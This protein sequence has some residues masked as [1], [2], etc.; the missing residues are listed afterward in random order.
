MTY[1]HYMAWLAEPFH[2]DHPSL[3]SGIFEHPVTGERI[4]VCDGGYEEAGATPGEGGVWLEVGGDL[5]VASL[6]MLDDHGRTCWEV[7][8]PQ[9]DD[10]D[11]DT[12]E[13]QGMLLEDLLAP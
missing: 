2:E 12:A 9:P 4:L 6:S 5:W 13:G 11:G 10:Y 1:D 8:M 3:K 7:R